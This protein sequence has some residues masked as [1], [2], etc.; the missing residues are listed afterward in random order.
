M[1]RLITSLV[2]EC[3]VCCVIGVARDLYPIRRS[4]YVHLFVYAQGC[5]D[6]VGAWEAATALEAL[7]AELSAAQV[8]ENMI[9]LSIYLYRYRYR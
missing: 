4:N 7:R 1:R 8:Q 9:N 2:A 5:G 3:G 6:R